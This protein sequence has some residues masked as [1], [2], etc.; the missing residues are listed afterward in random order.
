M[1]NKDI[2]SLVGHSDFSEMSAANLKLKKE[3]LNFIEFAK[4]LASIRKGAFD[5]HIKEGFTAE[6]AL[7]LCKNLTM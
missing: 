1:K 7:E 3:I 4:I 6:Q 2:I 5:A